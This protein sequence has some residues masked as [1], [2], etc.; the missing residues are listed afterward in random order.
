MQTIVGGL[1]NDP[2]MVTLRMDF[3]ANMATPCID[4]RLA[5]CR[6]RGAKGSKRPI[7]I[8]VLTEP[9]SDPV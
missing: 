9:V 4:A 3:R 7:A 8:F 6:C 1:A 5:K 2:A